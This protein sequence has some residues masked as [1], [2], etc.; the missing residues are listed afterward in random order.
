MLADPIAYVC[1]CVSAPFSSS[2]FRIYLGLY[3]RGPLKPLKGEGL[4]WVHPP[5]AHL[6]VLYKGGGGGGGVGPRLRPFRYQYRIPVSVT[7]TVSGTVKVLNG[8]RYRHP[9][10]GIGN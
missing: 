9:H 2:L 1:V 3:S 6:W 10:V 7:V 4:K 8:T 5:L